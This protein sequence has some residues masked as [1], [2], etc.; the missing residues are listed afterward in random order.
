M[1]SALLGTAGRKCQAWVLQAGCGI[2][3]LGAAYRLEGCSVR[4]QAEDKHQSRQGRQSP[5][6]DRAWCRD[7]RGNEGQER[8]PR[9]GCPWEEP[10]AHASWLLV[11][12]TAVG[13]VALE[14]R[15]GPEPQRERPGLSQDWG[16][17]S[18]GC[19]GAEL[20]DLSLAIWSLGHGPDLRFSQEWDPHH[21]CSLQEAT[22]GSPKAGRRCC[23][24]PA[25]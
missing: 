23:S 2:Q 13:Q 7:A 15:A 5:R 1:H 20:G 12:S 8:G 10:T 4:S 6:V 14:S 19:G 22:G 3:R 17:L 24:G 25:W 18:G 9:P 21:V 16:G 11:Y